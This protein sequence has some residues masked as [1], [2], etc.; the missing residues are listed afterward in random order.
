MKEFKITNSSAIRNVKFKENNIVSIKFTSND[1][2]YDFKARDQEAYDYVTQGVEKTY[3]KN[4]L[5]SKYPL[6]P[7]M[8]VR[9]LNKIIK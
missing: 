5:S 6:N 7:S 4:V 8:N 2:E 9:K 3:A 1:Q